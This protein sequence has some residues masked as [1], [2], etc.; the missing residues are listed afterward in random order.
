MT[1]A[2]LNAIRTILANHNPLEE[3]PGGLYEECERLLGPGVEPVLRRLRNAPR[4][5]VAP[6]VDNFIS[7]DSARNALRR[8]G[9]TIVI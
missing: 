4:V 1:P 3:G 6:H 8:A 9:Y 7:M 5:P 2:I